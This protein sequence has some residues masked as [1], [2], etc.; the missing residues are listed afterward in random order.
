MANSVLWK[1]HNQNKTRYPR[2]SE[3]RQGD[4]CA[5]VHE[6]EQSLYPGYLARLRSADR[7][8]HQTPAGTVGPLERGFSEISTNASDSKGWVVGLYGEQSKA[9]AVVAS[10]IADAQIAKWQ[11][12]YGRDPTGQQRAWPVNKVLRTDIQGAMKATK[13]SAQVQLTNLQA[14][15]YERGRRP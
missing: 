12:R 3:Y 1:F 15:Y 4:L 10:K 11:A 13:L 8:M 6:R 7:S 2:E 14:M 9:L 5:G